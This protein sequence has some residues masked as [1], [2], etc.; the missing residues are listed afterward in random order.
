MEFVKEKWYCRARNLASVLL[1][2]W[3]LIMNCNFMQLSTAEPSGKRFRFLWRPIAST[4]KERVTSQNLRPLAQEIPMA[5]PASL[6]SEHCSCL[7]DT[8]RFCQPVFFLGP[9]CSS[10]HA[11]QLL[12]SLLLDIHCCC[13]R[14][15]SKS[16]AWEQCE[17]VRG[18]G[19]TS[20][21]L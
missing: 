18:G 9:L 12:V 6:H 1:L 11:Y 2:F 14:G 3:N 20:R 10:G 8:S 5:Q 7:W 15:V 17:V 4:V 19:I 16:A 21:L 13:P